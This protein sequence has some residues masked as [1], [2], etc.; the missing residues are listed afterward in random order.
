MEINYDNNTLIFIYFVID[1]YVYVAFP[2]IQILTAIILAEDI[3]CKNSFMKISDWLTV[4]AIFTVLTGINIYYY[5]KSYKGSICGVLTS[6]FYY[7]LLIFNILWLILGIIDIFNNCIIYE[8][9]DIKFYLVLSLF[10][11]VM[12]IYKLLVVKR[13]ERRPLLEI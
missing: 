10:T 8:N 12:I 6:F 11:F 4:D 5:I 3:N 9:D 2:F 13:P 1:I 7:I